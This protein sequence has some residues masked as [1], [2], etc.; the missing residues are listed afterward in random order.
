MLMFA[1][2]AFGL[3]LWMGGW[4]YSGQFIQ[5]EEG[6]A[7]FQAG[8]FLDG[9]H[10][11][12]PGAFATLLE[13][14]SMTVLPFQDWKSRYF[15]GHAFW[16][17]PGVWIGWPQVMT[18]LAAALTCMSAYSI[19]WRLRIP[20]FLLPGLLLISPFF[21]FLH[22]TLLPQTSGM[23]FSSLVL[24]GYISWRQERSLRW[25]FL[26][27]LFWS[28]LLQIRPLLSV[29]L[30]IPFLI[31]IFRVAGWKENRT[32]GWLGVFL[33]LLT[34]GI[35]IWAIFRY[36]E[37]STGD[38]WLVT[39]LEFE[40]SETWGFGQR[41]T[42]GGEIEPVEHTLRRGA[43]LMWQKL[44]SL[45]RWML[46]AG[47][48]T[49]LVWLGLTAH[50]WSRRWSGLL[51]GVVV[52]TTFGYAGF[53]DPGMSEIGPLHYADLLVYLLT[54]GSLGLS[55]IW[56]KAQGH[57]WRQGVLLVTFSVLTAYFS[58]SF[59]VRNSADL[60]EKYSSAWRTSSLV[61]ALPSPALVFLPQELDQAPGLRINLAL[62]RR[63]LDSPVLRLQARPEDYR[64]L[65]ETFPDRTVYA[66]QVEPVVD[67]TPVEA[68]WQ[69]LSRQ[70]VNSHHFMGTGENNLTEVTRTAKEGRDEAGFLF[71]GWY[72]FLPPG[73]YEVRFELRWTDVPEDQ[74]VR[75]EVMTHLGKETMA[76]RDLSG[77]LEETVLTVTLDEALQVEPRIYFNGRGAVTLREVRI[78]R[79][80]PEGDQGE[81][82]SSREEGAAGGGAGVPS[83][84]R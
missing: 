22:G 3:S 43:E 35:G 19:G 38:P 46:G 83:L 13:Y 71:Y 34:M 66:L 25:A 47:P 56:R 44:R 39:Y 8:N 26:T 72:P 45:D 29:F 12:D 64:A 6:N 37:V 62:N 75:I 10:S 65:A 1:M 7:L 77:G 60:R 31:D 70:A 54:L 30:L 61:N 59:I 23:L 11:R 48:G 24:L 32:R 18:A 51:M 4:L 50:G 84:L 68:A 53:W 21:L 79:L 17:I 69:D 36:N 80:P 73:R 20:R 33:F 81:P 14:P 57:P 82:L 67:L 76:A 27:A 28:L 42:Q 40:P 58:C 55:R 16:L 15:P 2:L 74:P 49:L 63:G 41:R 78:R 5:E 9:T 52:L